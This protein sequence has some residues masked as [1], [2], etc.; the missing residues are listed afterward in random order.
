MEVIKIQSLIDITNTNVRRINQGTQ[1]ELDQ[2][3]NWTT[4]LQCI[5]LRSNIA[6]DRN[7]LVEE[8]QIDSMGFGEEYTGK[9][10]VWTFEFRPDIVGA[11]AN[12]TDPIYLLRQDLDSVPVI[13]NLSE[14]INI[15]QAV[16]NTVDKRYCNTVIKAT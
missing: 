11:F 7:P 10:R 8:L 16:F 12:K 15:R 4:L 6:Y 13:I 3:R 2:F 1:L 14:T 5:G 9:H